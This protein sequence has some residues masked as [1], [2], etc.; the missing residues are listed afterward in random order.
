MD[1]RAIGFGDSGAGSTDP[2]WTARG[3]SRA[4]AHSTANAGGRPGVTSEPV[5]SEGNAEPVDP[6]G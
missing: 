4:R 6:S 3:A 5:E 2:C 1:I